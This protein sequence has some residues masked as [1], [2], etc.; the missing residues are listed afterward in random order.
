MAKVNS[1]KQLVSDAATTDLVRL[2]LL[3]NLELNKR[4]IEDERKF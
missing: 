2:Q 1:L 3:I 4:L